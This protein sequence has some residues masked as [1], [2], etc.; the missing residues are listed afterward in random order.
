MTKNVNSS[1]NGGLCSR[2]GT[3]VSLD[4]SYIITDGTVCGTGENS[5]NT[6]YMFLND[7]LKFDDMDDFVAACTRGE[8]SINFDRYNRY[9]DKSGIVPVM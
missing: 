7:M 5:Y 6:E 8:D 9:W 4:C 1:T 2:N 3:N